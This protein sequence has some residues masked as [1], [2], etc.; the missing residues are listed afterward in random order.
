ME[1]KSAYTAFACFSFKY[2]MIQVCYHD[3]NFSYQG[4]IEMTITQ[5]FYC[6]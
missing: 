5:H 6:D 3:M 2:W 4:M 1:K